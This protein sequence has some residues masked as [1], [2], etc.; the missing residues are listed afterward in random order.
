[1][2]NKRINILIFKIKFLLPRIISSFKKKKIKNNSDYINFEVLVKDKNFSTYWFL[3]NYK[4][5]G[6]F[7]PIDRNENFNYLEIGSFEGLSSLF[8]LSYWKNANVTCVDTWETSKDESQFLDFNFQTVEKKFDTNLKD[9]SFR[10]IKNT[11]EIAFK[12]LTQRDSFDYIYIDGSHN[13]IDIYNDALASFNIL[14]VGGI[15]I[16]DDITNIYQEIEMQ[17]HDAFEKFYILYKRKIKILYLKNIAVIEK[18]N[19]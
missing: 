9:F 5:I 11:S 4:I 17:P 7:L 8:I 3:N 12:E 1:M 2:K 15:I 19:Y 13:G 10:K 14:K 6:S 18:T 16:F